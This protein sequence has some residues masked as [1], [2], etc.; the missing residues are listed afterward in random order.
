MYFEQLLVSTLLSVVGVATKWLSLS[1]SLSGTNVGGEIEQGKAIFSDPT[2]VMIEG[3][4]KHQIQYMLL[5]KYFCLVSIIL[6]LFP[7]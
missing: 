1:L 7:F 4:G 6:S 2:D 3:K 5:S